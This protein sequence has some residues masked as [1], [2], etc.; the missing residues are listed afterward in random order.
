MSKTSERIGAMRRQQGKTLR[1]LAEVLGAAEATVQRYESGAIKHVHYETLCVLGDALGCSPL[2]LL[3]AV[4]DP[5][6]RL[7]ESGYS[8]ADVELLDKFHMLS[9]EDR[10]LVQ[11]LTDRLLC[12][13]VKTASQDRPQEG[14][15]A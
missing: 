3:G 14:T 8:A 1:E 15:H 13:P 7:S 5:D 9:A 11:M 6:F 2:Y 10:A 12:G 4:E